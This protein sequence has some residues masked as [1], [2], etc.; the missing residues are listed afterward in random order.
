VVATGSA[1]FDYQWQFKAATPGS[2]FQPVPGATNRSLSISNAQ[3]G[4]LGAYKVTVS[5]PAG[6]VESD[7]ATLSFPTPAATYLSAV[8]ADGPMAYWR[9]G[10]SSGTT[11]A[12]D[13]INNAHPGEYLNNVVLGEPGAIIP[14]SNTAAR[15]N[16]SDQRAEI[17]YA[18]D[19]NTPPLTIEVWANVAG[20]AGSYRSPFTSR[21]DAPQRGMILYAAANDRWEFWNGQAAGGWDVLSGPPVALGAWAHLVAIH[22]GT[23][24]TFYVNGVLIGSK[25]NELLP[26]DESITRIG[27]GATE[28]PNGNYF[29]A[30]VIDEVAV[31]HKV[32]SQDRILTHFVTARPQQIA[33]DIGL[34]NGSVILTWPSGLLQEAAELT[35][36]WTDLTNAASPYTV[37]PLSATRRFYRVRN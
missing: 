5:N 26:N 30:G 1:T 36:A 20:N 31:Y 37:N 10:E 14:D 21:A 22:D 28:N 27:A 25:A 9:L 18:Q 4:S 6:T 2:A 12:K 17:P 15:F 35:G 32:L 16:G 34:S 8:M 24:K 29:F 7:P 13:E 23:N 33:I 19:L 11:E 3:T